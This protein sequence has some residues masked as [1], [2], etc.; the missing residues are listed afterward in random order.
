MLKDKLTFCNSNAGV[1][2][3]NLIRLEL[4]CLGSTD[5]MDQTDEKFIVNSMFHCPYYPHNFEC[6]EYRTYGPYW[7]CGDGE[8]IK[9]QDRFVFRTDNP[10][11]DICYNFRNAYYMCELWRPP[12]DSW[13]SFTMWTTPSGMCNTDSVYNDLS[14]GPYD[15]MP[16]GEKCTYL[17][18][19]AL[20]DG[21]E[22]KCPCN[23]RS[24]SEILKSVCDE[25]LLYQY[26]RNSLIA[27]YLL[28]FYNWT[29]RHDWI[30]SAPDEW[31][32]NGSVQCRG[33]EA[34]S[35]KRFRIENETLLLKKR[36]FDYLPCLISNDLIKRNYTSLHRFHEFCWANESL[37]FNNRSYG[38]YDIC[39]SHGRECISQYRIKDKIQDCSSGE[40]ESSSVIHKDFCW[41]L[42]GQRFR[43]SPKQ[44]SCINALRLGTQTALCHNRFDENFYGTGVPSNTVFCLSY[45]DANCQV[46]KDYLVNSWKMNA[47]SVTQGKPTTVGTSPRLQFRSYCNSGWDLPQHWDESSVFCQHWI[48]LPDQFRCRTGQC[49]DLEW[50]C[51][52]EWDC[53]DASDEEAIVLFETW[54]EHN[55]NLEPVLSERKEECMT[56][57]SK[58][59]SSN[60]CN[61]TAQQFLCYPAN[62]TNITSFLESN[63]RSCIH[64]TQIGDGKQDCYMGFDEKNTLSDNQGNMLGFQLLCKNDTYVPFASACLDESDCVNDVLCS[65][66]SRNKTFCSGEKDALCHNKTCVPGGRCNDVDDCLPYGE[67]EYW[68]APKPTEVYR[69]RKAGKFPRFVKWFLFPAEQ[70]AAIKTNLSSV[71]PA[72]RQSNV[73]YWYSY[74]CNRGVAVIGISNDF[75]CL[76]PP[77]YYG[78]KCQFFSDRITVIVRM[79]RKTL[80]IT[81]IDTALMIQATL[82]FN[83]EVMDHHEFYSDPSF[84]Y[85]IKQ[86]FYLL[87]SR[88][89]STLLHK[90]ARYRNRSDIIVHHPYSIRFYVYS[91]PRNQSTAEELGAWHY[92][93]Y[94]DFLPAYR[95]ATVL[96]FPFW[97]QVRN[98]CQGVKCPPNAVCKPFFNSKSDKP[99]TV[100]YYCSCQSGFYGKNCEHDDP[101]CHTY[102]SSNSICRSEKRGRL[103]NTLNPFCVC[104]LGYFGARCHLRDEACDRNPCLNN[105]TCHITHDPSGEQ[106]L[107][108]SCS[109]L[110]YGYRC[111]RER[112]SIRVDIV[113]LTVTDSVAVVAQF[114]DV[115]NET[116]EL[117]FIHQQVYKGLPS[118]VLYNHDQKLHPI[119]GVLKIY[120]RQLAFP[121]YYILYIQYGVAKINVTSSPAQCPP[122]SSILHQSKLDFTG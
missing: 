72:T 9:W 6:D 47:T 29:R 19:C 56:R 94:F 84:D 36:Q 102:C 58:R 82:L 96:K 27:P 99:N 120:D 75:I 98:P 68:C 81:L 78:E 65:Y 54:V 33:F 106:S 71:S 103:A 23:Q 66:R 32:F 8:Y 26:P 104:P 80:P 24:C 122:V 51:D 46:F 79:D 97:F 114:Y 57:Y 101:K 118:A 107:S 95:L 77:A 70:S 31:H 5:C 117:Q 115:H 112:M 87:Y 92:S 34:S 35:T 30:D 60:L 37:T 62:M 38:F 63:Q 7:S 85:M 21:K 113:N 41:S 76:C 2:Y 86:Q 42:R 91:L 4:N 45:E 48:C 109:K 49:I 67:D 20:S 1:L 44:S 69:S 52:G 3:I 50:V 105:G 121:V 55:K 17:I 15:D 16:D 111:E 43:C 39:T 40:D 12:S 61:T 90:K 25:K 74:I 64:L 11:R 28:M 10:D 59:P 116:L 100:H 22:S 88:S 89:N 93:V 73:F 18:R 119:L 110:F 108:C 83:D 14:L 13:P 53:S